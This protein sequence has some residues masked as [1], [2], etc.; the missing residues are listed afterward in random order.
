[1]TV[2]YFPPDFPSTLSDPIPQQ[3]QTTYEDYKKIRGFEDVGFF[4]ESYVASGGVVTKNIT[5]NDTI[6]VTDIVAVLNNDVMQRAGTSFKTKTASTTYYLDFTKDGDWSWETSHAAGTVNVDYLTV[7]EVTTDSHKN[8][9][10]ITDKAD[11]RGGFRL[12]PEY[13]IPDLTSRAINVKYPPYPLVPAA[14]DG[15][16]DDTAAIQAI[17]TYT[18]TLGGGEVIF[19]EGVYLVSSK[20]VFYSNMIIRGVAA[21]LKLKSGTYSSLVTMLTTPNYVDGAYN[22]ATQITSNV[23]I[24]GLIIDGNKSNITTTNSCTGINAYKVSNFKVTNC[25]IRQLPGIIGNGYGII[26]WYS[27]RVLIEDTVIDTTDRQ[28]ICIWETMD[29]HIDNCNLH[30]SIYRDCVLISTNDVMAFQGSYC[31]L[32]NC[33]LRNSATIDTGETAGQHVI[34]VAGG[35]SAIIENNEIYGETIASPLT[36]DGIWI[37]VF[38]TVVKPYV[39]INNNKI[40]NCTHGISIRSDS[41]NQTYM[42]ENNEINNCTTNGIYIVLVAETVTLRGNKIRGTTTTPLTVGFVNHVIVDGNEIDGGAQA[43]SFTPVKTLH[44]TN[45]K[46]RNLT[47]SQYSML[48][49]GTVT[50]KPIVAMNTLESNTINGIRMIID[51]VCFGN[52]ASIISAAVSTD[53]F[54]VG[55]S[56]VNQAR[57]GSTANRPSTFLYVGFPYWDTTLGK[58]IWWNG[59]VW[60]DATGSTV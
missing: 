17:F 9:D 39:A 22:P 41:V 10:V 38:G 15:I 53:L 37:S 3:A 5:R 49:N 24:D 45:N 57:S 29:A 46:I 20:L 13:P 7:A 14:G 18:N 52:N 51:G 50:T 12:K 27:N 36:L 55:S 31:T 8:V 1:M 58:P 2:R 16:K 30:T 33:V 28:N 23:I 40:Y 59:T 60:K 43:V 26:T 56:P 19:P 44:V 47:Y 25:I 34:R 35:A 42:I 21:T 11:P 48:V 4:L 54:N 32:T 6:D